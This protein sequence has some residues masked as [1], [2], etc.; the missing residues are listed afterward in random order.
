M[1]K[2]INQLTNKKS[3][4]TNIN[5][6]INNEPVVTE[7]EKIVADSLN[8]YFNEIGTV[9][10]K[11]LPKSNSSFER[12]VIPSDKTFEINRL[13]SRGGSSLKFDHIWGRRRL[14]R[15]AKLRGISGGPG[16]WSPGKFRKLEPRKCHFLRFGESIL[17]QKLAAKIKRVKF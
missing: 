13:S 5:E 10:A 8:T 6:L 9:L 15:A 3:K 2:T 7:P 1:W 16:V 11:D 14:P 12:Y 17:R 4:T